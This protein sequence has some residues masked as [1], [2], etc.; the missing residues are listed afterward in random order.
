M[1]PKVTISSPR[2]VLLNVE[3][4]ANL[5]MVDLSREVLGFGVPTMWRGSAAEPW[6]RWGIRCGPRLTYDPMILVRGQQEVGDLGLCSQR[7]VIT[8]WADPQME[9]SMLRAFV[10]PQTWGKRWVRPVGPTRRWLESVV[11][12]RRRGWHSDPTCRHEGAHRAGMRRGIRPDRARVYGPGNR[13]RPRD[14]FLFLFSVSFLNSMF[15]ILNSI[16]IFL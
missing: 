9:G 13:F 11:V 7:T 6:F 12:L 2:N 16:C 10:A 1:A 4:R 5:G 14:A 3:V 15:H 8:P